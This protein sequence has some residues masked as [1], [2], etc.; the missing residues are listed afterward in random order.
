MTSFDGIQVQWAEEE[1]VGFSLS[2][3]GGNKLGV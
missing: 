1:P 3:I 2:Q